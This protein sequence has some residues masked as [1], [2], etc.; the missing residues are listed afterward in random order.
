MTL[1]FDAFRI[2]YR[3]QNRVTAQMM[4]AGS[5][6]CCKS[7][8]MYAERVLVATGQLDYSEHYIAARLTRASS[9]SIS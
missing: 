7:P 9:I 6:A 1:S 3:C 2:R 8:L 4:A 5:C